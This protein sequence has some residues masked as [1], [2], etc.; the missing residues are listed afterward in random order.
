M[1]VLYKSCRHFT[2]PMIGQR[3]LHKHFTQKYTQLYQSYLKK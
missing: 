1:A 2:Q 3:I